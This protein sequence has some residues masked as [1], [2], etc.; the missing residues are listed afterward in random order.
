M[1]AV[2]IS[3]LSGLAGDDRPVATPSIIRRRGMPSGAG[4]MVLLLLGAHLVGGQLLALSTVLATLHAGATVVVVLWIALFSRRPDALVGAGAYVVGC[5]VLWRQTEASVPWQISIY[6]LVAIFGVGLVRF[7][8]R[9]P[10]RLRAAI[11]IVY[12]V[13]LA[14]GA[15]ATVGALGALGA[16]ELLGFY[17]APPVALALGVLLLRQY[18]VRWEALRPILWLLVAPIVATL[19]LATAG[20]IGLS[21][22]DFLAD[23][24]NIV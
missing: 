21:A 17:L 20:A 18:W 1:D 14:P 2:A 4:P 9:P 24:S 19:G 5:E 23:E 16:Q 3:D 10:R 12:L 7:A 8:A 13:L 15:F 22:I 11:P 6:L